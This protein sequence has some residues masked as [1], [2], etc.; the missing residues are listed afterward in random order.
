[1]EKQHKILNQLPVR[2]CHVVDVVEGLIENRVEAVTARDAEFDVLHVASRFEVDAWFGVTEESLRG[3]DVT[4]V[5]DGQVP[6]ESVFRNGEVFSDKFNDNTHRILKRIEISFSKF[7][8]F[9]PTYRYMA[10]KVT[11]VQKKVTFYTGGGTSKTL[12]IE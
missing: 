6:D 3:D 10:L 7:S 12:E 4:L 9:G 2:I 8:F 1:M 11:N 5:V